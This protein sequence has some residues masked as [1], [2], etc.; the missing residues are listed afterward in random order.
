MVEKTPN[1]RD[2]IS[3]ITI[4]F[5]AEQNIAKTMESVLNQTYHNIEYII[6]DG[7]SLDRTN[8]IIEQYKEKFEKKGIRFLHIIQ[9]DQGIY[10]AMNQAINSITGQYVIYMNEIG[11]AHV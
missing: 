1:D 8:E 5:N 11:R 9:E 6:K 2:L 7:K 10:D 4:C 3:I